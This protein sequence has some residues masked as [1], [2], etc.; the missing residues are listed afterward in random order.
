MLMLTPQGIFIPHL[1]SCLFS[2]YCSYYLSTPPK[3]KQTNR[4]AAKVLWQNDIWGKDLRKIDSH[5]SWRPLLIFSFRLS[6]AAQNGFNAEA[7]HY[8]GNKHP[9]KNNLSPATSLYLRTTNVESG[10]FLSLSRLS[11]G[12]ASCHCERVDG[13]SR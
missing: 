2:C 8:L 9:F 6:H 12:L 7:F 11:R 4:T 3:Y 5:K 13:V 1:F 10:M